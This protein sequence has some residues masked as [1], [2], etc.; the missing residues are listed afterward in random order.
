MHAVANGGIR[1]CHLPCSAWRRSRHLPCSVMCAPQLSSACS[2]GSLPTCYVRIPQPVMLSVL[3]PICALCMATCAVKCCSELPWQRAYWQLCRA[4]VAG[5][6]PVLV[7]VVPPSSLWGFS[8]YDSGRQE[9]CKCTGAMA[10]VNPGPSPGG[11]LY[12]M[13]LGF[14]REPGALLCCHPPYHSCTAVTTCPA[15]IAPVSAAASGHEFA[16]S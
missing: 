12:C 15:D 14:R 16:T 11:L 13:K 7:C 8:F 5:Q 1:P 4:S 3:M 6:V 10:L 2:G 9:C